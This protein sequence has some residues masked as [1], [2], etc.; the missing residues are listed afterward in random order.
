MNI[1]LLDNNNDLLNNSLKNA[2]K[3]NDY[4]PTICFAIEKKISKTNG[5]YKDFPIKKINMET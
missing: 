5:C 3:F 4:L 1:N 2:N